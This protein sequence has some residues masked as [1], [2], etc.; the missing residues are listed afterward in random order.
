M[1]TSIIIPAYNEGEFIENT[2]RAIRDH[3]VADEIIVVDDG[4]T[5]DTYSMAKNAGA[6]VISTCHLGKGEAL[7]EGLKHARG[8]V[9]V[10][11]DADIGAKATEVK[12]L[13]APIASGR[14]DMSVAIFPPANKKGGFGLV[15]G[16]ARYGVYLMT[17][18][19]VNWALSGQRAFRREVLKDIILASGFGVEVG[20]TVEVL[21]NGFR[22]EEVVVD[23]GHRETGRDLNG[24]YHRGRQFVSIL[25]TLIQIFVK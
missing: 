19:K 23:M 3:G 7:A 5:D 12:K 6:T 15:K 9:I 8:E 17:G 11:L 14:A 24:F 18:K 25:K 21:R 20:L 4:S 10:F 1:K 2:I 22:V 16:L 13:I